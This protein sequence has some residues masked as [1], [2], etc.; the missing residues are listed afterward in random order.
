MTRLAGKVA[1]ITGAT[2]GIG[3]AT[4]KAYLREGAKVM[5]VGRSEDKLAATREQL[6]HADA[7]ATFATD[8]TDENGTRGA[9]EATVAAFGGLDIVFANAG[10]EGAVKPLTEQTVDDFE[11]V[12]RTNVVGAWLTIKHAVGALTESG[13]GA[14]IVTSSIAGAIGF[15]GLSAYVASKHA[16][17]GLV[18]TAALELAEHGIRV[19]A[20]APGMIDNRMLHSLADQMD[21]GNGDGVIEGLTP[22]IPLQR[23]G[24]SEE[25]AELAVFLGGDESSYCTG[26]VHLMDGGYV[27]A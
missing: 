24:R 9:I 7:T 11:Q 19:N 16:V 27:A 10:T 26:S 22:L 3:A 2:G 6:G 1:L 21:A 25:I 5:L 13:G 15:P 20:I 12:L 14:V 18:K 4:A 17:N 8:A 23:L